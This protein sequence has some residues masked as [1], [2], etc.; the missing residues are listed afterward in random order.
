MEDPQLLLTGCLRQPVT[1][2][3]N[4]PARREVERAGSP[5]PEQRT[6]AFR[7]GVR[8]AAGL[9]TSLAFSLT[10]GIAAGVV[11]GA[12][13]GLGLAVAAL[14][15]VVVVV[16]ADAWMRYVVLLVCTRGFLPWQLATFM[17][18]A[19]RAGLLRISGAAYQFRH[20]ALQDWLAAHPAP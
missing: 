4:R 16:V 17:D 6:T 7:Y 20:R 11:M 13:L 5:G 9:L 8:L 12:W 3:S 10:A 18:W 19:Y 15:A 1:Y 2:V 14:A